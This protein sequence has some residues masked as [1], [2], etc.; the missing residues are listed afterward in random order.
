MEEQH[1]NIKIVHT[2]TS[3][4]IDENSWKGRRGRIDSTMIKEE[5]PDHKERVFYVC[6]P[7]KMV[8]AIRSILSDELTLDKEKIKFEHFTGY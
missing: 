2:L 3:A 4:G 7:P 8:E 5:I 1:T 6:G